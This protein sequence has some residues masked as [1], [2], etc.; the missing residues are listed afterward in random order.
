MSIKK[1]LNN[2]YRL[3]LYIPD[4]IKPMLGIS[5]KMYEKT[6]KTRREAKQAELEEAG[7]KLASK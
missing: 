6:F 5:S 3:R 2:T 4:E 1:T 7:Q